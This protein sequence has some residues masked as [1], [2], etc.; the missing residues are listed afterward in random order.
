MCERQPSWRSGRHLV[1]MHGVKPSPSRLPG[2]GE[3]P[4]GG[5]V[6]SSTLRLDS[7]QLIAPWADLGEAGSQLN[8]VGRLEKWGTLSS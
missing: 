6:V 1:N 5:I 4:K 3:C 2:R 7:E 8:S